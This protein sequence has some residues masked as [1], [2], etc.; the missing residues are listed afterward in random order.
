MASIGSPQ[1]VIS[2]LLAREGKTPARAYNRLISPNSEHVIICISCPLPHNWLGASHYFHPY[3]RGGDSLKS[4]VSL[5]NRIVRGKTVPLRPLTCDTNCSLRRFS[6]SFLGLISHWE[7]RTQLKP[8][9]SWLQ[10]ITG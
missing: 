2:S 3:S 6:K 7:D 10:F 9:Y 1:H 5:N 4:Y 8:V